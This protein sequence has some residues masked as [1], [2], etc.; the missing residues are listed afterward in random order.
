MA[1]SLVDIARLRT[2]RGRTDS[3]NHY[4]KQTEKMLKEPPTETT[5][6]KTSRTASFG[7]MPCSSPISPAKHHDHMPRIQLSARL[8]DFRSHWKD[9]FRGDLGFHE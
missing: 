5:L 9:H 2:Q 6:R 3:S 7:T 4:T 8:E 1:L